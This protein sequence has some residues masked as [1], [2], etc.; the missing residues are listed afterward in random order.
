M[1]ERYIKLSLIL[2]VQLLRLKGRKFRQIA[3]VLTIMLFAS[4]D[5][6]IGRSGVD[7]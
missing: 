5:K 4:M 3:D 7:S 6:Q 1:K 2:L